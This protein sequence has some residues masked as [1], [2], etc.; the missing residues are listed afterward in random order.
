[1]SSQLNNGFSLLELLISL[2]IISIGILALVRAQIQALQFSNDAYQLSQ[3]WSVQAS[4]L[5]RRLAKPE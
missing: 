1:M 3:Q 2:V 5:E 4:M